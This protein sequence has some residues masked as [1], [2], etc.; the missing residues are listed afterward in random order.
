[1][2]IVSKDTEPIFILAP[3]SYGR[4]PFDRK[5]FGRDSI[6]LT[7]LWPFHHACISL[8]LNFTCWPNVSSPIGIRSKEMQ[9]I[10]VPFLFGRKPFD[11]KTFGWHSYDRFTSIA[12]WSITLSLFYC[13]CWP[14]VSLQLSSRPFCHDENVCRPKV[15]RPK[16]I[17]PIFRNIKFEI[18]NYEKLSFECNK[19]MSLSDEK[20]RW[21]CYKTFVVASLVLREN[22]LE[23]LS[24]EINF[25]TNLTL[26]NC[27][28]NKLFNM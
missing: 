19:K 28:L 18:S 11:R 14:N 25:P 9:P 12:S 13:M 27:H 8:F 22:K 16:D 7:Q 20:K 23:R 3:K 21:K 1:M 6:W 26:I 15:L 10:L 5:T 4:I 24:L 17:Q 2:G